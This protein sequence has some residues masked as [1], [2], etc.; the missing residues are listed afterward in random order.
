MAMFQQLRTITLTLAAPITSG[1]STI[2]KVE[3]REPVDSGPEAVFVKAGRK[4]GNLV[5]DGRDFVPAQSFKRRSDRLIK[6]PIPNEMAQ[7]LRGIDPW[8]GTPTGHVKL[9]VGL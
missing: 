4:T 9:I 3:C 6:T 1:L 5:S 2:L 7:P 8:R